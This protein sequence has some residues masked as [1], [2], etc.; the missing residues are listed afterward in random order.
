MLPSQQRR[1]VS[2][3][4]CLYTIETAVGGFINLPSRGNKISS[5]RASLK[6]LSS[7]RPPW[8][9]S[10]LEGEDSGEK[11][12]APQSFQT[13]LFVHFDINETILL[14]DEAGGDSRHDSVQKMLA[15]SAF[16]QLQGDVDWD[17]TQKFM[18]THWWDGQ[19]MDNAKVVPSLYTGWKWPPDACPFYR[20]ALKPKSQTFTQ[21]Y[22]VFQPILEACEKA[23]ARDDASSSCA[24]E[25]ASVRDH[26][27]PAFWTTL[28]HWMEES[29]TDASKMPTII[30]RTFGS[31]LGQIAR[32]VSEFAQGQH[33]HFPDVKCP[34]LVLPPTRLLQGRWK[35][36]KDTHGRTSLVYQ[37]WSYPEES[38]LLAS[39][40]EEILE[41]LASG[42]S[43]FGIRDDYS[44][45][46]RHGYDPTAG[47]PVWVPSYETD[48]EHSARYHHHI[49]FDDNI[50]NLPHDGIAC[51]RK[52]RDK[53]REPFNSSVSA[54]DT[55]PGDVM[56]HEHQGIHL[57]RVPT[58]EPVLNQKWFLQ[59]IAAAQEA[60]QKRLWHHGNTH[61]QKRTLD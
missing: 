32:I 27:L 53:D 21:H 2:C 46:K 54:Y 30:F 59:Q 36:L 25:T 26:I 20:T 43:I 15:K 58:I 38:K 39:G 57:V 22:P 61:E 4:G 49:L 14:G 45:W 37:L 48:I 11:K 29:K 6:M 28:L 50:H 16:V 10:S 9:V 5:S 40:D 7:E 13:R 44:T 24:T 52:Q 17:S 41:L 1:V 23:L 56:H 33:P 12:K 42:P 31:D 3:L 60:V 18:P 19:E 55:V 34:S 35:E 47:K 8:L 51:V